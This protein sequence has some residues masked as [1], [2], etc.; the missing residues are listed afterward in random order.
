MKWL[1][2]PF[3]SN[4]VSPIAVH[5]PGYKFDRLIRPRD[6]ILFVHMHRYCVLLCAVCMRGLGIPVV[7]VVAG[8]GHTE[9]SVP[10]W[11]NLQ[12]C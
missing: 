10:F 11:P 2:C 9:V 8:T 6:I 7:G 3:S 5:G 1:C 12:L 4:Q